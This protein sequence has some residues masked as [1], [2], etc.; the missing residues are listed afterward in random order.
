MD[1][2]RPFKLSFEFYP[3]HT[4]EDSNKLIQTAK[5]LEAHQPEFFS[6]TFGA[7]G[8]TQDRGLKVIQQLNQETSTPI[9]PHISCVG[10]SRES[11]IQLLNEYRKLGI[12][13]LVVLR[14]DMPSGFGARSGDFVYATDLVKFIREQTG[15]EFFIDVAAYPE[16]HPESTHIG[17]ELKHFKEK[18]EN[19][20]AN[21]AITQ[22]FYNADAY[23]HFRE[24]C[25]QA[26]LT[27]EIIPGIMPITN[28]AQ[29][30]KFS[31]TCGAE[32]PKW[33]CNKLESFGDDLNSLRD[34]GVEFM[35]RFC[36]QL[37]NYGAPE[38]HFY[39]LNRAKAST[40][41]IESLIK[42]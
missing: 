27:I 39:T 21:R 29:L 18:V 10:T 26:G 35:T 11:I 8:S 9:A 20:G 30:A 14:G 1:A 24:Q 19:G 3:P 7:G 28:Y 40:R 22:Y 33:L 23:Y 17:D 5:K 25:E 32:I 31:K 12:K 16:C 2:Q 34:F 4:E 38:L 6:V 42:A 15:D 36:E 41:I 37:L 13:Q